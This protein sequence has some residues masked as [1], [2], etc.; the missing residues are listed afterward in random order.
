MVIIAILACFCLRI[1]SGPDGSLGGA[2]MDCGMILHGN[3][4]MAEKSVDDLCAAGTQKSLALNGQ[5]CTD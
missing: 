1:R 4:G 5:E 2:W 3:C